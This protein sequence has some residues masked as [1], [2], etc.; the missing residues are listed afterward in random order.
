[1]TEK[2]K[3]TLLTYYSFIDK[4][5]DVLFNRKA[6]V[7]YLKFV[8]RF[9]EHVYQNQVLLFFQN[10]ELK[11]ILPASSWE[12]CNRKVLKDE[13]ALTIFTPIISGSTKDK[14]DLNGQLLNDKAD[15]FYRI[16]YVYDISQTEGDDSLILTKYHVKEDKV[17]YLKAFIQRYNLSPLVRESIAF[18]FSYVLNQN[19]DMNKLYAALEDKTIQGN[20]QN[21]KLALNQIQFKF[22]NFLRD[23]SDISFTYNENCILNALLDEPI[24]QDELLYKLSNIR[25]FDSSAGD[26]VLLQSFKELYNK[27]KNLK[28]FY[29]SI[30]EMKF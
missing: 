7:E 8:T 24:S 25:I 29:D 15:L 13:P 4:N 1:M 14:V 11:Y 28:N 23:F 20:I 19:Y 27:S 3:E 17:K 5:L 22:Y 16:S 12:K 6:F 2:E 18:M 30:I 26:K 21:L 10:P 9:P